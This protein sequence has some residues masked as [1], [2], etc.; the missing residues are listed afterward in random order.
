MSTVI[1]AIDV[2]KTFGEQRVSKNI[3]LAVREGS[4]YGLLGPNGAGK[5]TYLNLLAGVLDPTTGTLSR[6]MPLS[7]DSRTMLSLELCSLS[8]DALSRTMLSLE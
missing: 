6:T 8:N 1:E 3:S 2:C 7:L 4:I 5:S